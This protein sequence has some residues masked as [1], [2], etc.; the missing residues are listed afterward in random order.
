MPERHH[1]APKP[2]A[3]ARSD[4]ALARQP[5][6]AGSTVTELQRSIGNRAVTDLLAAH[7]RSTPPGTAVLSRAPDAGAATGGGVAPDAG[8]D[9][10][11][12]KKAPPEEAAMFG[13]L[14]AMGAGGRHAMD[15]QGRFG[16]A[17]AWVTSGAASFDG[18]KTCS[19]ST[20]LPAGVAA[21][22]FVHEMYHVEQKLTGKSADADATSVQAR[23]A[24]DATRARLKKEYVDRMVNEEIDGTARGYEARIGYPGAMMPGEDKYRSAYNYWKKEGK[25]DDY[26]KAMGRR[27]VALMLRPTDGS[28]PD[29]APSQFESYAMYYG[30]I[31][32][33]ANKPGA[34]TAP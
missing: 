13:A 17:L 31:W 34:A 25:D 19:I 29:L 3:I 16:I 23:T 22:Y 6:G 20:S 10:A 7:Q 8:A 9:A 21:G 28:W 26:A 2:E 1:E 4:R 12:K 11:A 14:G 24:D 30:R 18:A 32:D 5:L 27:R 33:Q 15:I